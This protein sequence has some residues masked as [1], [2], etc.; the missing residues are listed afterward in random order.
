MPTEPTAAP[1]LPYVEPVGFPHLANT[2]MET[3]MQDGSTGYDPFGSNATK[4]GC[5]NCHNLPSLGN[6]QFSQLDLSHVV[7]K[8]DELQ[9]P[10]VKAQ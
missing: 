2:T 5:F 3:F 6:P 4:A 9:A 7:S 8:F 10:R 1:P